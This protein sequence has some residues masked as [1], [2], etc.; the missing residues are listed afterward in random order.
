MDILGVSH[1]PEIIRSTAN[2]LNRQI[3]TTGKLKA[4]ASSPEQIKAI[5]KRQSELLSAAHSFMFYMCQDIKRVPDPANNYQHWVSGASSIFEKLNK[6]VVSK[7]RSKEVL[8]WTLQLCSQMSWFREDDIVENKELKDFLRGS[9]VGLFR[10]FLDSSNDLDEETREYFRERV[11][12][13]M[14]PYGIVSS[15]HSD[16]SKSEFLIHDVTSVISEKYFAGSPL[17]EFDTLLKRADKR[18]YFYRDGENFNITRA[19]L[20]KLIDLQRGNLTKAIS[21]TARDL[22]SPDHKIRLESIDQLTSYRKILIVP[23][24][25]F[26][27]GGRSYSP[28]KETVSQEE[29]GRIDRFIRSSVSMVDEILLNNLSNVSIR[30][31]RAPNGFEYIIHEDE[32]DKNNKAAVEICVDFKE[33]IPQ[34]VSIIDHRLSAKKDTS[35]N[36]GM[37]YEALGRLSLENNGS[38][39]YPLLERLRDGITKASS[40]ANR[41][42]G[43]SL[44]EIVLQELS[45]GEKK[46]QDAL[47]LLRSNPKDEFIHVPGIKGKIPNNI[48]KLIEI[49]DEA[50]KGEVYTSSK[51]PGH[52]LFSYVIAASCGRHNGIAP[53]LKAKGYHHFQY[54]EGERYAKTRDGKLI[55]I[56]DDIKNVVTGSDLVLVGF[57]KKLFERL[58]GEARQIPYCQF[59]YHGERISFHLNKVLEQLTKIL[60]TNLPQ[61]PIESAPHVLSSLVYFS[62]ISKGKQEDFDNEI[63]RLNKI[64]FRGYD[65]LSVLDRQEETYLRDCAEAYKKSNPKD[66]E[67]TGC[68]HLL[69]SLD[70]YRFNPFPKP[71]IGTRWV[72]TWPSPVFPYSLQWTIANKKERD[73]TREAYEQT[74]QKLHFELS[75]AAPEYYKDMVGRPMQK[76][77]IDLTKEFLESALSKGRTLNWEILR[78]PYGLLHKASPEALGKLIDDVEK[79]IEVK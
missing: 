13:F 25:C 55:N 54:F 52:S 23:R 63:I 74:R 68:P 20:L 35:R 62:P 22:R 72:K 30:V 8:G 5:E 27:P 75:K 46:V 44:A 11:Y 78:S 59:D 9:V 53:F 58:N 42:I 49:I 17:K 71:Q 70:R 77:K 67:E 60:E 19:F 73:E 65:K 76:L 47:K 56:N 3:E 15:Y 43:E 6:H 40:L 36:D 37:L 48:G 21:E 38:E 41:K 1:N 26:S 45:V 69:K 7:A 29:L 33:R 57:T 32:F 31:E 2:Y 4:Q 50:T 66:F 64:V 79:G 16:T 10:S 12:S 39:V 24:V 61:N 18:Y 51:Q 14:V 28:F 34:L